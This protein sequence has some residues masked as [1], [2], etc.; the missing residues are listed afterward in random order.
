MGRT[1][2]VAGAGLAAVFMGLVASCS[3]GPSGPSGSLSASGSSGSGSLECDR[4]VLQIVEY[5]PDAVG[6][7]T[8]DELVADYERD[9]DM[10]EV[11]ERSRRAITFH[12]LRDGRVVAEMDALDSRSGWL[13]GSA[14]Y[15]EDERVGILPSRQVEQE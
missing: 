11:V 13:V 4:W 2:R 5:G 3:S 12:V 15:C 9:G 8:S 7:A 1:R 6:A 14:K 10:V